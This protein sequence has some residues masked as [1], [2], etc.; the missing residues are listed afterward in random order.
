[1][2]TTTHANHKRNDG[3]F[4]S[5]NSADCPES[6]N[7]NNK[8]INSKHAPETAVRVP[9]DHTLGVAKLIIRRAADIVRRRRRRRRLVIVKDPAR[10]RIIAA[11]KIKKQNRVDIYT[12]DHVNLDMVILQKKI[13]DSDADDKIA[14]QESTQQ[15][16]HHLDSEITQTKICKRPRFQ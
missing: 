13:T 10:A 8:A 4:Y 16:P 9:C 1:M 7:A 12:G 5:I 6:T 2:S 11:C 15:Q 14:S 3:A